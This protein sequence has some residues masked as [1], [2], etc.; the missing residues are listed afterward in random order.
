MSN[1]SEY[2]QTKLNEFLAMIQP[3]DIAYENAIFSFIGLRKENS[4]DIIQGHLI[5]LNS[6]EYIAP[7]I[8]EAGDFV[9][10]LFRLKDYGNNFNSTMSKLSTGHLETPAGMA[11][12]LPNQ[13]EQIS[14]SF[15]SNPFAFSNAQ[16]RINKFYFYG[17]QGHEMPPLETVRMKLQAAATPYDSIEELAAEL[18]ITGFRHDIVSVE[19]TASN[20]ATVDLSKRV[21]GNYAEMSVLL[22][23]ALSTEQCSLGYKVVVKGEVVDRGR[24]SGNAFSWKKLEANWVG[25]YQLPV[26]NGA[27][28]QCFAA[29]SGHI[30]HR[31]WIADPDT[32]PNALRVIHHAFDNDLQVIRMY[33]L[34]EKHHQKHSRD[35][36]LGIANLLFLLGFSINPLIGKPLE[37]GPDIIATTKNGNIVL[38]ECTTGQINKDG[39]LGKLIDRSEIVKTHLKN[40]AYEHLRLLPVII[41]PRP[42]SALAE[43]ELAKQHGILVLTQE[44]ISMALER[45]L[46][47][48][49]SDIIFN[50]GWNSIHEK[51]NNPIY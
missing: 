25:T 46:T 3:W 41:S 31:G 37:D 24:L 43:I 28:L 9:G 35:F 36:E 8:I 39:K 15:V 30:Q 21:I 26:P 5:F 7:K 51:I 13:N 34:D 45:T 17:A 33:L 29:Y 23:P 10:C 18:L 14:G 6:A 42:R 2:D 11:K 12:I 44:D 38:I 4:I 40:A 22:A 50:E 49:D 16:A 1:F 27:V 20:V 47:P 32:F 19:V 48:Q